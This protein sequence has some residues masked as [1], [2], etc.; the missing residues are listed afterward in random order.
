MHDM[1]SAKNLYYFVWPTAWGP[2]GAV[3]GDKGIRRIV[4][5]H[6]TQDDLAALLAW[7]HPGAVEGREPFERLV[8]LSRAFLNGKR[9]DFADVDIDLPSGESFSGVVYRACRS[10]P[11][12]QTLSYSAL[13]KQIGRPDAARAVATAMSKNPTPLIVPCHRVIYADG[14][15]GGFSAEGG[16]ALKRRL[17]VLEAGAGA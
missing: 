7:E 9:V 11:Y 2:M 13:A 5:P 12:G 4:L 14:R 17:L 3:A 8:E 6:Y 1:P 15:A 10:I 16:E